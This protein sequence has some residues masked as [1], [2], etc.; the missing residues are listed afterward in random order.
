MKYIYIDYRAT[1]CYAAHAKDD[2]RLQKI[3]DSIRSLYEMHLLPL[4]IDELM[5]H[6]EYEV[7]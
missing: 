7:P 3:K 6:I 1:F 2:D 4:Q 5:R